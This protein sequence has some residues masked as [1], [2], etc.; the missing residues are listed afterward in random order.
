MYSSNC[1]SGA[2]LLTCLEDTPEFF[3]T[4]QIVVQTSGVCEAKGSIDVESIELS[5]LECRVEAM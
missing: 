4:V 2:L 1:P 3:T 5:L